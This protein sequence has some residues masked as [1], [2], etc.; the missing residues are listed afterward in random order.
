LD[1]RPITFRVVVCQLMMAPETFEVRGMSDAFTASPAQRDWF[2]GSFITGRGFTVMVKLTVGPEHVFVIFNI[3]CVRVGVTV[4]LSDIGPVVL[5]TGITVIV[6]TP[7][8][9]VSPI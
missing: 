3:V 5:F 7:C 4:M 8:K 1:G 9:A 6:F 2:T